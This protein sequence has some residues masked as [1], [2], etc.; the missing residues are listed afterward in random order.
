MLEETAFWPDLISA[1]S[2]RAPTGGTPGEQG[3]ST[4]SGHWAGTLGLHF[5]KTVDPIVL[6]WGI[7]YTHEFP[8][9][10]FLNDGVYNV[11]PGE[12]MD[13]NFGFGFAVNDK[14]SLSTQVSGEY[15]WEIQADDREIPGSSSEPVS[16]R[17]ALT[18]RASRKTF[19]EPSL[20][21]G[22]NDNTPDFIIGISVTQHLG[23]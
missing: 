5:I 17:Q 1:I 16:L 2:I 20:N 6:F 9:M 10:H 4:G 19:I 7:R 13:Y 3:I 8:A 22:L 15:Q 11:Q 12:S 23:N 18:F 21:I 14:V